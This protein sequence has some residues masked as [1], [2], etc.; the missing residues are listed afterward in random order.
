MTNGRED[1]V[2]KAE[3]LDAELNEIDRRITILFVKYDSGAKS[4]RSLFTFGDRHKK[5]GKDLADYRRR[6]EEQRALIRRFYELIGVNLTNATGVLDMVDKRARYLSY[7]IEDLEESIGE[8]QTAPPKH[9]APPAYES[10]AVAPTSASEAQAEPPKEPARREPAIRP[11]YE[12]HKEVP[13]G[14]HVA[15]ATRNDR[16]GEDFAMEIVNSDGNLH[17]VAICDGVTNANGGL[18]SSSIAKFV[19][20][21]F[22]RIHSSENLRVVRS[23]IDLLVQE[24]ARQLGIEARSKGVPET[25][26]TLLLAFADGHGF[27]VYYLGD[28]TVRQYSE[29]AYS[30]GDYL[31]TYERGGALGGY[32]SSNGIVSR[33]TFLYVDSS[34][35]TGSFLVLATD[36]AELANPQNHITLGTMLREDFA[37]GRKPLRGVL[38]AY[39]DGLHDRIDDSTIGVI[40]NGPQP[41]TREGQKSN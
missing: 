38:E 25:A 20:A 2:K 35:T 36:G 21:G 9:E 22:K 6:I 33:P 19:Q 14:I 28:G 32:I 8:P 11:L 16:H 41:D 5:L 10:P 24:A 3:R 37:S 39:L 27:Y 12:V 13:K 17:G 31:M 15:W 40:W 1:P 30:V 4:P 26:T 23:Q 34:V 18:A 7:V 29:D